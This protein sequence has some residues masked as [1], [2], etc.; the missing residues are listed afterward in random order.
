MQREV[1]ERLEGYLEMLENMQLEMGRWREIKGER[2][3]ERDKRR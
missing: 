3:V 1:S 2:E